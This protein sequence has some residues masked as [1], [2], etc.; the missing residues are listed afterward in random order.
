MGRS[1]SRSARR[2]LAVPGPLR[3]AALFVGTGRDTWT[4]SGTGSPTAPDS[5]LMAGQ[6]YAGCGL[7]SASA[8]RG[9]ASRLSVTKGFQ[10]D[11]LWHAVWQGVQEDF[12]DLPDVKAVTQL[13]LRML[14]A[15]GL[16]GLLGYQRERQGKAAGLRT[17]M[18]YTLRKR[19]SEDGLPSGHTS[20]TFLPKRPPSH[21][22]GTSRCAACVLPSLRPTVKQWSA[23]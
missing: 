10:M 1:Q 14:L 8:A 5:A 4:A 13:V 6:G 18:L 12:S 23:T 7:R 3:S 16:G 21:C 20:R 2:P 19:F 17:H 11:A 9:A 15:V 22:G